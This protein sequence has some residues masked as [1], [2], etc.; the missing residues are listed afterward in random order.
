MV[1]WLVG[2]SGAGKSTLAKEIVALARERIPNVVL[3][4][5]D[6]LREALGND[7]GHTIKDRKR[8]AE[9][10]CGLGKLLDGQGIHVVCAV[11]SLFP[12]SREWNRKHLKS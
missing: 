5:G 6:S 11:L 7:L 8:N 3:L 2:L 10:L 12:E 4:D 1:I 9:R